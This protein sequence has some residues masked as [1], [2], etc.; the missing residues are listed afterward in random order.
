MKT[1]H[2]C[3][4]GSPN[5]SVSRYHHLSLSHMH[6]LSQ[7]INI[8]IYT[9]YTSVSVRLILNAGF[10]FQFWFLNTNTQDRAFNLL[11]YIY[12]FLIVEINKNNYLVYKFVAAYLNNRSANASGWSSGRSVDRSVGRQ[13]SQNKR[14]FQTKKN[15]VRHYVCYGCWQI[16]FQLLPFNIVNCLDLIVRYRLC[17]PV[18]VRT[19]HLD[20]V[21]DS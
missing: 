16:R 7:P 5:L 18:W 11:F 12:N 19:Q 10:W 6:L 21:S 17:L 4:Y 14:H 8:Y 20:P 2:A 9:M 3:V 1:C 15:Y 13:R